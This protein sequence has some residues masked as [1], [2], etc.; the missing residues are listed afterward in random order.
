MVLFCWFDFAGLILLV[1]FC[2][3]CFVAFVGIIG[4]VELASSIL[5]IF[6]V[7][8]NFSLDILSF[9]STIFVD[10]NGLVLF[11]MSAGILLALL[12]NLDLCV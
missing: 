4:Y 6:W 3:F 10:L 7:Y 5:I 11:G 1:W 8:C 9:V 12:F 2:W